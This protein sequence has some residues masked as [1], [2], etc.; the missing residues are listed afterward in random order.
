MHASARALSCGCRVSCNV[1][2]GKIIVRFRNAL[3]EEKDA[4]CQPIVLYTTMTFDIVL[5]LFTFKSAVASSRPRNGGHEC[6]I[7]LP[8]A[9][10][11]PAGLFVGLTC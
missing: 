6:K 2:S 3:S 5:P 7:P 11:G 4:N 8:R 10:C 9:V 1:L